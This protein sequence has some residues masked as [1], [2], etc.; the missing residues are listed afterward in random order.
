M[1]TNTIARTVVI[2]WLV[3]AGVAAHSL[4]AASL[5]LVRR[6]DGDIGGSV[7]DSATGAPLP[8][9]EVRIMQGGTI[10]ATATT[11]AFGRYL[12]HNLSEGSYN[13]EV[14]YLGFRSEARDV[15]VGA[16]EGLSQANFRLVPLAVNL[17]AVEVTS[18]VPLAVDTRTGDQIFK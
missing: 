9:G 18:T 8:G 3:T 14:R 4:A 15:S 7:T 10:V 11:D 6:A 2:V 16:A 13:V 12:V 17:S 5:G 1:S